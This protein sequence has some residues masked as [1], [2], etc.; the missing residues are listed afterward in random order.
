[1]I[2]TTIQKNTK[3][4]EKI[5]LLCASILSIFAVYNILFSTIAYADLGVFPLLKLRLIQSVLFALVFA[6]YYIVIRI[7]F[8]SNV[9]SKI[10][11]V[12]FLGLSFLFYYLPIG[13]KVSDIDTYVR[14][15]DFLRDVHGINI[16]FMDWGGWIFTCFMVLIPLTSITLYGLFTFDIIFK[17]YFK[18]T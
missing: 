15:G 6:S 14:I 3:I 2:V 17:K 8:S 11:I 13:G 5:S 1:M 9:Y 12:I 7:L 4:T 18:K 16:Y 10:A